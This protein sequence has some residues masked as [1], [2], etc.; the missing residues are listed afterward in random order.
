MGGSVSFH[1]NNTSRLAK[2]VEKAIILFACRLKFISCGVAP[3]IAI[4]AEGSMCTF[5][6][7]EKVLNINCQKLFSF[8]QNQKICEK[9]A[10][11]CLHRLH[12][13]SVNIR[14]KLG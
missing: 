6:T 3:N 2:R 10:V 11:V 1:L 14:R 5:K 8:G 9:V 4:M 7:S 12:K 13:G